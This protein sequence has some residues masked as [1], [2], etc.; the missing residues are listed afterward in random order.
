MSAAP[1]TAPHPLPPRPP[2]ALLR[3]VLWLRL[4]LSS[5]LT[6]ELALVAC[7]WPLRSLL[8]THRCL[9]LPTSRTALPGPPRDQR[10]PARLAPSAPRRVLWRAPATQ[11]RTSR[12][13]RRLTHAPPTTSPRVYHDP[14]RSPPR[15]ARCPPVG[16]FS[17]R[18]PIRATRPTPFSE[19]SHPH[20][21]PHPERPDPA[22]PALYQL[23]ERPPL[24]ACGRLSTPVGIAPSGGVQ[25]Q[26][27]RRYHRTEAAVP[28]SAALA[29]LGSAPPPPASMVPREKHGAAPRL[30]HCAK[31]QCRLNVRGRDGGGGSRSCDRQHWSTHVYRGRRRRHGWLRRPRNGGGDGRGDREGKVVQKGGPRAWRVVAPSGRPRRLL[32]RAY[33][34]GVPWARQVVRWPPP[35]LP[36]PSPRLRRRHAPLSRPL[37][38]SRNQRQQHPPLSMPQRRQRKW[39]R[40]VA[41]LRC[42]LPPDMLGPLTPNR[43]PPDASG[44]V[45]RAA[46]G[47]VWRCRRPPRW[48]WWWRRRLRHCRQC[49]A[50][51][52]AG[53]EGGL[54]GGSIGV[55]D[56]NA[57]TDGD[58]APEGERPPRAAAPDEAGGATA[59][60]AAAGA[61]RVS[62]APPPRGAAMAAQRRT[63]GRRRA[64][65]RWRH[66]RRYFPPRSRWSVATHRQPR[67][68]RC[69]RTADPRPR[70]RPRGCAGRR[71]AATGSRASDDTGTRGPLPSPP[72]LPSPATAR[73]GVARRPVIG[74][75]VAGGQAPRARRRRSN[76]GG[77]GRR[78]PGHR[79][80]LWQ[81]AVTT[82]AATS[83][84]VL[85]GAEHTAA[86]IR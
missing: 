58:A 1:V 38:S 77:R 71:A 59:V 8:R 30:H 48:R 33:G 61:V 26:T 3:P 14:R 42:R 85:V 53:G 55:A 52:G 10:S 73:R 18:K 65:C 76:I 6:T 82:A 50:T 46:A 34:A 17:R 12:D 22:H 43:P 63:G 75:A 23:S 54:R 80:P 49:S 27:P 69:P 13:I 44:A 68:R 67:L 4:S 81:A 11:T 32:G 2:L 29:L 56:G 41:A 83:G 47:T 25:P 31:T 70:C 28:A 16:A 20:P 19:P 15:Q 64:L 35:L 5:A 66:R 39:C 36:P 45:R 62:D 9:A 74:V 57:A 21:S 51:R 78:R 72:R 86:A 37:L 24:S 79:R 40:R 60:H 84:G 7:R